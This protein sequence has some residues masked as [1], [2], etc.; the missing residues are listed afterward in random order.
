MWDQ[1]V[2]T[3]FVGQ[4]DAKKM[5]DDLQFSWIPFKAYRQHWFTPQG[6]KETAA[7]YFIAAAGIWVF[8]AM[9][10]FHRK[11]KSFDVAIRY[12]YTVIAPVLAIL[13]VADYVGYLR[14]PKLEN[15]EVR[16][17]RGYHHDLPADIYW[18]MSTLLS[19][20]PYILK[21]SDQDIADAI[22]KHAQ[23]EGSNDN[24]VTGGDLKREDSPGNFTVDRENDRVVIRVYDFDGSVTS[25][26]QSQPEE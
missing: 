20:H 17:S 9:I 25:F 3:K 11:I 8:S 22:L 21:Y 2:L 6:A 19:K 24:R 5:T 23:Q 13:V 10:I 16:V 4:I 14:M 15:S 12:F 1:C 18:Q 26:R 7:I